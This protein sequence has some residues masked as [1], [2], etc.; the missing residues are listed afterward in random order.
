MEEL[1]M[2]DKLRSF[3]KDKRILLTGHTGFKGSWMLVLLDYLG[4]KVDAYALDPLHNEDLY[5]L[6][7]G[8]KLCTSH[9]ADIRDRN[10]VHQVV[11]KV[12]PDLVF[13]FAAQALVRESYRIPVDT[14]DTNV[15]GTVNVLEAIRLLIKPCSGVMITTDKV[16]ENMEWEFHYKENDRLGGFDPYSSSKAGAEIAIASYQKAFFDPK[17]INKHRKSIAAARGGNVIGGG[18]WAD[19][20]IIPDLVRALQKDET[21]NIRNPQAI[22][23]WQHVLEL[24]YGYLLLGM[25]LYENPKTFQGAYNFGPEKGDEMTVEELVRT[26]FKVWGKGDY[27]HHPDTEKL[28]EAGILRLEIEKSKTVLDWHPHWSSG[29]AVEKTMTWY[30]QVFD[31][32]DAL[33]CCREQISDYFK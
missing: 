27:E 2:I 28:H 24:L 26:A 23:P 4:A 30:K 6:I 16:Y 5:Y 7:D 15:M 17:N 21:L 11:Q 33:S 25:K 10:A 14:F 29:Q 9:I 19:N 32:K 1:D 3:Y 18:D 8:D 13:H 12:Q 31:G 20:R 22:R